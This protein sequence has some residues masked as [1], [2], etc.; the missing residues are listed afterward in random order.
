MAK[1]A[2][3]GW[4]NLE[5]G[6]SKDPCPYEV[7]MW[8]AYDMVIRG[9]PLFAI[10][11]VLGF[12]TYIRPGKLCLLRHGNII[13]PAKSVGV[14]YRHWTILLHPQEG[15]EPSKAGTFNDSL[16][17]GSQGREWIGKMVGRLYSTFRG[18]TNG[19]LFPFNL[20]Q[21]EHEFRVSV[22]KLKLQKLRLT[23]HCL[24]HGGASHDF[25]AGVRN[26]QEIQQRGCWAS[27][28]S[29]RRYSKHGR[30]SK[31]LHLLTAK[32]Q[33]AA[34]QASLELPQMLM[35]HFRR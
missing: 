30:I 7:A 8:I 26:L 27:F 13:P 20:N 2:K 28:E 23:P 16:V 21:F 10:A 6:A 25:L 19:P 29:V 33:D 12:D 5:P 24:R 3:K 34:K 35:S 1:A 31:Q 17:V 18:S 4:A 11:T 9:L 14:H 15:L 22:G 32:Q